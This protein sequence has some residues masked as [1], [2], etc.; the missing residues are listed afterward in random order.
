LQEARAKALDCRRL[1]HDGIDPIEARRGSRLKARLDEAKAMTSKQC[2]ES[3]VKAH[4]SGWRNA[5]H[6]AQR[7]CWPSDGARQNVSHAAII[8]RRRSN[9]SPRR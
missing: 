9:R 1:R 2:A 4:R 8:R 7:A 5:K 6:A 3:Y